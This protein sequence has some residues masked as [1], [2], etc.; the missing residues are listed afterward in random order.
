MI[1]DPWLNTCYRLHVCMIHP[2]RTKLTGKQTTK[3]IPL[4]NWFE[5]TPILIFV[6]MA[7]SN[8]RTSNMV[9]SVLH[10][11]LASSVIQ[12]S[13]RHP[14]DGTLENNCIQGCCKSESN[15]IW[16]CTTSVF[17]GKMIYQRYKVDFAV[18]LHYQRYWYCTSAFRG[19]F[20]TVS[21]RKEVKLLL[22]DFVSHSFLHH[23]FRLSFRTSF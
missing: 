21:S 18:I 14:S 22:S 17:A 4:K 5:W 16:A 13:A 10:G 9:I 11:T 15:H 6:I 12:I 2:Q 7:S 23:F 3:W 20:L 1:H 19:L 8:H